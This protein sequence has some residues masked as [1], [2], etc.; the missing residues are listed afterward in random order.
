[1]KSEQIELAA[2]LHTENARVFATGEKEIFTPI[3]SGMGDVRN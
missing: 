3:Q 1:M 2:G